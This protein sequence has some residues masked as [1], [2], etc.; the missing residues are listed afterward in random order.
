L[1]G[2]LYAIKEAHS[3]HWV[4]SLDITSDCRHRFEK[5]NGA[6]SILLLEP[7]LSWGQACVLRDAL[8]EASGK[9][10]LKKNVVRI[11]RQ[12]SRRYGFEPLLEGRIRFGELRGTSIAP[13]GEAKEG[14]VD[15]NEY[16]RMLGCMEGRSLS[17]EELASML[18]HESLEHAL[19]H[20]KR[21]VQLGL[22]RGDLQV[23]HGMQMRKS[24][25]LQRLGGRKLQHCRRCGSEKLHYTLCP[26][27]GGQCP[28]CEECLNMGRIRFCSPL[29]GRP[30]KIR[31][32][33]LNRTEN[34]VTPHYAA[35]WGLS[36][37]Q[38]AAV[39][40]GMGQLEERIEKNSSEVRRLL[41]WAVTGAGKTEML[42]PFI[43]RELDRGGRVLIA[44]PRRD[45]VLELQP[46]LE[47]AFEGISVVTLH[48]AST[49][50][51]E[52]GQITI[53][54][55]HQLLRF[56]RAFD[57][58]VIDEVDAFPYHNNPM[59]EYAANKVCK[60]GGAYVLLTATPPKELQRKL[61]QGKLPHVKVPVRYHRHAL[62]V[63][64]LIP[65]KPIHNVLARAELPNKL[66]ALLATS[67]ERGAQLFVF[68]P[69]IKQVAPLV[70]LLRVTFRYVEIQ[71]TSSQDPERG[72]K[73]L[74]FRDR[75]IRVLVTT[76][77]LERGVTVPKSDVFILDADS[78][79]F[80]EGALVQMAGRAGRSKDDP[81]GKVYFV[82]AERTRAQVH[83]VRQIRSMNQIARNEGYFV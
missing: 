69:Y 80:D 10:L 52:Q 56:E 36:D 23:S 47:K 19:L 37:A 50:R 17:H 13:T 31:E 6:G 27:C 32:G 26:H 18:E 76:T 42:F 46:R 82:A 63:P 16:V 41:I 81:A 45:V 5:E 55:T 7:L 78:G 59:L 61:R 65:V 60:L 67:L 74:R 49:Q 34:S 79:M 77:I 11:V 48:G 28:Y 3:W 72:D 25:W 75:T 29:I 54:T 33:S 44:S 1:E 83:A 9:V 64:E 24:G 14:L 21:Y 30:G 35:A 40:Q 12:T 38:Q 62:P 51:W 2:R 73:V 20:W 58:V 53:S 22:L 70:H 39:V 66:R 4:A 68:V 57:L 43:S 15:E 71:G 8:S